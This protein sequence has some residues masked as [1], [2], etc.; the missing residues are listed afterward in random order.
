MKRDALI[1]HALET[2]WRN[3]LYT[4]YTRSKDPSKRYE[5]LLAMERAA[6]A[7]FGLKTYGTHMTVRELS[8]S[9]TTL[10]TVHPSHV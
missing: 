10:K 8:E 6:C 3:E 5:P 1:F 4:I 7:L 9:T 2:G